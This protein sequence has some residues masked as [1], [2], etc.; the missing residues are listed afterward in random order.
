M[1][2]RTT[3]DAPARRKA[4]P[5]PKAKGKSA[6]KTKARSSSNQA[7]SA[8]GSSS[9]SKRPAARR[10]AQSSWACN[11]CTLINPAAL[12]SCDAC[13]FQR[14]SELPAASSSS[15]RSRR[16]D[17][18][19]GVLEERR[20]ARYV[21]HPSAGLCD[22]IERAFAQRLYLLAMERHTDGSGASFKVMGSTGNVYSVDFGLQPS[23]DCP[24]FLKGRGLCKHVLF[25][26][27]RVLR[28]D[29]DDYRIWQ[30]ALLS[31]ELRASVEPVFTRRAKRL[32]P[33]ADKDVRKTFKKMSRSSASQDAEELEG[34]K[35]DRRCRQ[36]IEGEDCPVCFEA[37]Q[38]A[39]EES[40]KLVFCLACGNNFH[41]DCIHRWQRASSG[42][43]P[44]CRETW[45]LPARQV[46]PGEPLPDP[47]SVA[48]FRRSS[49]G[50][51]GV[52]LNLNA[53][54]GR[55]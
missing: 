27:L 38:Q 29:D 18:A 47:A 32:L 41:D 30:N 31:T 4:V 26:W 45:Q 49:S 14:G 1:V 5:K 52:Y 2:K 11:V 28:V 10:Q 39:E 13:G 37:M 17:P 54:R 19:A 21:R 12:P 9:T 24:D 42:D 53:V 34:E 6:A 15:R 55:R 22:R 46:K 23:C 20:L 3:A 40:G 7:S 35:D 25:I 36:H 8:A 48:T 43:C 44:L 16:E 33:L 51:G 50:F